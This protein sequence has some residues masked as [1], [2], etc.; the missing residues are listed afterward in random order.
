MEQYLN[1]GESNMSQEN[2][3]GA[4]EEKMTTQGEKRMGREKERKK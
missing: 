1:S 4:Y 3:G 2:K